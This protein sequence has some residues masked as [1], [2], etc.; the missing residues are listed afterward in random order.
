MKYVVRHPY[1]KQVESVDLASADFEHIQLLRK[2]L[3][4][5]LDLEE[6]F[7]LVLSNYLQIES[8]CM[9]LALVKLTRVSTD[10]VERQ[11]DRAP[12]NLAFVNFL[13]TARMYVDQAG[14]KANA[15]LEPFDGFIDCKSMLAAEYDKSFSYRF[16]EALRNHVQHSGT[17]MHTLA[18]GFGKVP[19]GPRDPYDTVVYVEPYCERNSLA[20]DSSFKR[21]VLAECPEKVNLLSAVREYVQAICRVHTALRDRIEKPLSEARAGIERVRGLLSTPVGIS[22]EGLEAAAL[23]ED[24]EV[25]SIVPLVLE[26]ENVRTWLAERNSGL[27]L[28]GTSYATGKRKTA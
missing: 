3:V 5:G 11:E 4:A 16:I 23:D 10:Y 2:T 19:Q 14:K 12:I 13:S 24:G 6:L 27:P 26:W 21:R 17:A 9:N 7:D 28:M 1:D 25:V 8:V 20:E 15:C 18:H 22:P